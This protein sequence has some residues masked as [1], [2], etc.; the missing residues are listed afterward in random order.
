LEAVDKLGRRLDGAEFARV[1][2][3]LRKYYD[4]H[5]HLLDVGVALPLATSVTLDAS[6]SLLRRFTPDV[7]VRD[8][9][10]DEIGPGED[11]V[12]HN[13]DLQYP[14]WRIGVA[15]RSQ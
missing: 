4:F 6:P 13:A 2:T 10:F 8:A 15:S 14:P 1:R 5:F 11:A 7:L 9:I 12:I 3:Q